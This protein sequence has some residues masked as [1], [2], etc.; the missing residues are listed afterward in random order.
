MKDEWEKGTCGCRSQL[1]N[2]MATTMTAG[3]HF[4]NVLCVAKLR[5][6]AERGSEVF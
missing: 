2:A 3:S 6:H 4:R 5:S 1:R